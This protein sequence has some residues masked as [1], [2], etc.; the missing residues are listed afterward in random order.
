MIKYLSEMG[1]KGWKGM[2]VGYPNMKLE[3]TCKNCS[4]VEYINYKELTNKNI[5]FG[6]NNLRGMLG[7]LPFAGNGEYDLC[8]LNW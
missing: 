3:N 1:L 4:F 7:A 6:T 8:Y 2:K 5:L